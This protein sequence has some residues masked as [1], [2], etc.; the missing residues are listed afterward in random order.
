MLCPSDIDDCESGLSNCADNARCVDQV[1]GFG[2]QCVEGYTGD[3]FNHC[4]SE[5]SHLH[6]MH[7][8]LVF[9]ILQQILMNVE[10]SRINVNT[11]ALTPKDHTIAPVVLVLL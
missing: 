4:T 1:E 7:T 3:G 6:M 2:C 11:A 8:L 5:L 9:H 10:L